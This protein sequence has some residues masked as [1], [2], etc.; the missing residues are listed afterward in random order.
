MCQPSSPARRAT[1]LKSL[2]LAAAEKRPT[3]SGIKMTRRPDLATF[4]V[5][6]QNQE[7]APMLKGRPLMNL[8]GSSAFS[9]VGH[10]VSDAGTRSGK[11]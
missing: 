10:S 2:V 11:P 3:S 7:V 4:W 9:G 6:I 5:S 1:V 8:F